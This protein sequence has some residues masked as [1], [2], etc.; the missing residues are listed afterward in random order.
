[1]AC[2]FRPSCPFQPSVC[3]VF[4]TLIYHHITP[5]R[6]SLLA[7]MLRCPQLPP[8]MLATL[9]NNKVQKQYKN[10]KSLVKQPWP[11]PLHLGSARAPPALVMKFWPSCRVF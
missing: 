8:A 6:D 5:T 10:S 11:C 3:H 1:M 4:P 9:E 2:F 7:F